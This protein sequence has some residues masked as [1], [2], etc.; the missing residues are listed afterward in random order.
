LDIVGCDIGNESFKALCNYVS[1][2]GDDMKKGPCHL[3][4]L[5]LNKCKISNESASDLMWALRR[6]K[7]I[8]TLHL[9]DVQAFDDEYI[10]DEILQMLQINDTLTHISLA[11]NLNVTDG[12]YSVYSQ[13]KNKLAKNKYIKPTG[14]FGSDVQSLI[15]KMSDMNFTK[16]K[17]NRCLCHNCQ[18]NVNEL[19]TFRN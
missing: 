11:E 14:M 13:I 3:N 19:S 6:N 9:D 4:F 7:T 8:K 15:S 12:G 17:F 18:L 16:E 2:I 10:F 1:G 5:N